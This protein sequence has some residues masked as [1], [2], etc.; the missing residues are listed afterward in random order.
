MP[1]AAALGT[2]TLEEDGVMLKDVVVTQ[3]LARTRE[4]PVALSQVNAGDI[5]FKLG[6]QE[7]P[8]ILKTTPGV[9]TTKDGGGFGDAK[10]NRSEEA[11]V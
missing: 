10:T 7:F 4:T 2:I 1:A 6:T 8:E 3:S 11:H 5:E 9:W